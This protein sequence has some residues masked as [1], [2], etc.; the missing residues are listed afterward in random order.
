[1]LCKWASL[2]IG[3]PLGNLEGSRLPGLFEWK[4]WYIWVPFVDSE[5]I[6]ILNLGAIRNVGKETGLSWADIGLWDTK[7]HKA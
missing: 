4:V 5:Y 6:K 7:G 2:S 3:A 1:M